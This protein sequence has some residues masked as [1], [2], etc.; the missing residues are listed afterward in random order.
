[1]CARQADTFGALN[2]V[3]E[4]PKAIPTVSVCPERPE[5]PAPNKIYLCFIQA[6]L[7]D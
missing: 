2:E 3:G 1:M 6:S 5:A 4:R 7:W